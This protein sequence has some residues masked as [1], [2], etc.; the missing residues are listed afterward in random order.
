M[1]SVTVQL[2]G[3]VAVTLVKIEG[4]VRLTETSDWDIFID[5]GAILDQ[6]HQGY[7]QASVQR[8]NTP[9]F[10]RFAGIWHSQ[11]VD[12]FSPFTGELIDEFDEQTEFFERLVYELWKT[13]SRLVDGD[14]FIISLTDVRC[15][16]LG[17]AVDVPNNIEVMMDALLAGRN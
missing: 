3:S 7:V 12:E 15:P 14:Q 9:Q 5:P 13:N 4:G 10:A 17:T 1:T 6:E 16:T 8:G 2:E 11:T